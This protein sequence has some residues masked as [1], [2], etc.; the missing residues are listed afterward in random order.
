MMRYNLS[1]WRNALNIFDFSELCLALLFSTCF[2]SDCPSAPPPTD[3]WKL[4]NCLMFVLPPSLSVSLFAL[5]SGENFEQSPLRRTFKSKVL[6]HFP[7]NV[8]WNPF[9]QDAVGMVC[10]LLPQGGNDYESIMK[11]VLLSKRKYYRC[12]FEAVL[13]WITVCLNL[14]FIDWIFSK[15]LQPGTKSKAEVSCSKVVEAV[16]KC[17]EKSKTKKVDKLYKMIMIKILIREK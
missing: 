8:E 15:I 17:K 11:K 4:V 3:I 9:D 12:R 7:D 6:A 5:P 14:C 16:V 10:L 1:V 13:L 2:W